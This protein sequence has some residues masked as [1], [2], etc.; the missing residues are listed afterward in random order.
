M[1][2]MCHW[3][4]PQPTGPALVAPAAAP[5]LLPSATAPAPAAVPLPGV[6]GEEEVATLLGMWSDDEELD[7]GLDSLIADLAHD[8]GHLLAAAPFSGAPLP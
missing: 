6:P 3:L 8:A 5:T 4:F 2:Q 7:A 1:T